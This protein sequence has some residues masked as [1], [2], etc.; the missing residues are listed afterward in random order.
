M[1]VEE[2]VKLNVPDHDPRVAELVTC[3]VD[4]GH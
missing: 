3:D 2:V 4:L 1:R